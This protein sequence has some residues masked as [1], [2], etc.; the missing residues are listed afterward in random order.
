[1]ADAD[2]EADRQH[3]LRRDLRGR[4]IRDRRVLAAMAKVPRDRFIEPRF[5]DSAYADRALGIACGQTI[6]QPY[7]VGLMTQS[8]ELTGTERVL[9]IGTG[10]GYQAA[11]LAELVRE[12]VSIERHAALSQRAGEVLAAL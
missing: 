7:I 12:V 5:R 4:G 8:L 2:L 1:M 11:V 9:E 3:M 6:S 10:S